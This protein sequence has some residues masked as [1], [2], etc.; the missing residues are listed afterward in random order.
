MVVHIAESHVSYMHMQI[1]ILPRESDLC[2]KPP[3]VIIINKLSDLFQVNT[4]ILM[5]IDNLKKNPMFLNPKIALMDTS[6]YF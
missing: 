1:H 4:L 6:G 5:R 2:K 3:L